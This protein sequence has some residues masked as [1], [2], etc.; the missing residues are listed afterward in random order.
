V[1]ISKADQSKYPQLTQYVRN[2]FPKLIF[3][4]KIVQNMAKYGALTFAEFKNAVTWNIPPTIIITDLHN[5]QCG[6]PKTYGCFRQVRPTQ[7]EIHIGTINDFER[8][9]SG[10]RDKNKSGKSVYVVGATLLHELCHWGNHNN[11]P[12]I[13]E[14]IEMGAQFERDTYGKIIY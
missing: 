7:I 5:G 3:V 8:S 14:L 12:K 2:A 6:V 10:H 11:L 9:N 13:P 4:P 1:R